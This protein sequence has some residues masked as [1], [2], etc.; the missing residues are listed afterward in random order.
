[1]KTLNEVMMERLLQ[2]ADMIR[3]CDIP[4]VMFG[5]F[6]SYARGEH[7]CRSDIDFAM[8]V[9]DE[10]NIYKRAELQS[11]MDDIGCGL[12]FIKEDTF[13]NGDSLFIRAVRRDWIQADTGG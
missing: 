3:N 9:R 7:N 13:Y 4:Y 11:R 8:I 2:G 5:V 6:G 1:M 12:S 10:P